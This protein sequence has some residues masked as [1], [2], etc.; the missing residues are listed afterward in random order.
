MGQEMTCMPLAVRSNSTIRFRPLFFRASETPAHEWI[1]GHEPSDTAITLPECGVI[2]IQHL[3]VGSSV[4]RA[5]EAV[6]ADCGEEIDVVDLIEG[7][8]ELGLVEAMLESGNCLAVSD[9]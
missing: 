9:S 6:R 4:A 3:Q 5:A 8:A 1:V 7:L 2:A